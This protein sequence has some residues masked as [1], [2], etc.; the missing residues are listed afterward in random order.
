MY[1]AAGTC[2]RTPVGD[3]QYFPVE[4]GL[5]Q[6]SVLSPLLF[7]IVLDVIT[8]D[9]QA[10]IPWCML[11]ADDIVL[12][13]ESR[14]E[15][16]VNLERWR[17][18][19][20]G[21]GLRLSR[22]KT[23]YLWANF[24]EEIHEEDVA[25]CIAEARVPQTNTFK[26]LGSIIQSNGDIS[27]DV[28]HRILTGWLRWRSAT[29]VLCDKN[30]PL[31]LK[32]K[33]YR[34]AIRPS[35]LY[36]SEC[37]PLRKVQ[38]RRLETAE[39]RMLRWICG[40]TMTDHI[41]SV[42]FRRLLG[43]E[44]ISKKIREGRLRWYGHVRRKCNSVPVRRVEHLSVR[45]KRKRGRPRRTW[46]DQLSLDLGAL[47][48]TGDMTFDKNDWRRRIKVVETRSRGLQRF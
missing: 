20:E 40:N 38:E 33:F 28:T 8:R 31:K 44:P 7:I 24:S 18:S 22:S 21:Y 17:T 19:L 3:T 46:S 48:L 47:N 5:H 12:V 42:T 30:V 39:M 9:I 23:E 32:G 35:L 15:V 34:V 4:V 11:F 6:G 1:S 36:G 41:P 26:Y 37:W 2:V 45:G 27:A 25:V 10:P 43:V 13:A 29:G 16:N 14:T